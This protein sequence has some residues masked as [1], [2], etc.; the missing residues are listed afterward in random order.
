VASTLPDA[1]LAEQRASRIRRRVIAMLASLIVVL[2]FVVPFVLG[3]VSTFYLLSPLCGTHGSPAASGMAY[4]T[5]QIVAGEVTLTS[6]FI[7][8]ESDAV[9]ILAPPFGGDAG[10]QLP[11]ARMF[12]ELDLNVLSLPSAGCAGVMNTLGYRE[13]DYVTA[14]Y[15]YLQTRDDVDP[16][17]VSAHG[18]SAAGAAALFGTA[19]T[20]EIQAVSAMGNYHDFTY[21]MG[22][23]RAGD[24]L[25]ISLYKWGT[26]LTWR[27]R[28]GEPVSVLRPIAHI[29]EIAPRPMLFIYGTV[30]PAFNGGR[31][32]ADLA[33]D[34]GTFWAVE[35][36]GHGGYIQVYPDET[37]EIL[38]GFHRRVLLGTPAT[39]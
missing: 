32:M 17:K 2:I 18:F 13:G 9:V 24:N 20:P 12:H 14:A 28:T 35:G 33:G 21:D 8:A 39:Q 10:E 1:T 34:A 4:E 29:E 11:Y 15:A 19:R 36:V 25:T 37:R 22:R 23:P 31:E 6:Y 16:S 26:S 30:E 7:P 3:V 38:G 5:V 27:W